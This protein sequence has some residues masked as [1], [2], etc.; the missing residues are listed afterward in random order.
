VN[1]RGSGDVRSPFG[2]GAAGSSARI[3]GKTIGKRVDSGASLITKDNARQ[4]LDFRNAI[5]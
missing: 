1:L 5:K 4:L 3:A 2:N